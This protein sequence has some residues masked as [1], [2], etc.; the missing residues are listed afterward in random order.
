M[1]YAEL[2]LNS[3][4]ENI[5]SNHELYKRELKLN[6]K[7]ICNNYLFEFCVKHEYTYEPDCWIAGDPGTIANIGD[8][9]VS[10]ENIRYDIDNDIE[11]YHFENWYWKSLEVYELTGQNYI[12]YK[13]YCEGCPDP[14]PESRL[15]SIRG[16]KQRV[17]DAQKEL[18]EEIN[19]CKDGN[20]KR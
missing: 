6:W 20:N 7:E 11:E 14:W 10:M 17:I 3:M 2:F 13:S 15:S 8:M 4:N 1:A 5:K 19:R 18:E 16:A 12:N 9:F